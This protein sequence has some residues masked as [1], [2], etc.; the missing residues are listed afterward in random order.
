MAIA[1]AGEQIT[2]ALRGLGVL[3][4]QETATAADAQD[5]LISLNQMLDSWSTERLTVFSMQDQVFTWPASTQIRTLGPSGNFVG[6][7]PVTLDPSTYFKDDVS[8][9]SIILVNQEQY[10]GVMTE[11]VTGE[12]PQVLLVNYTV[13]DVTMT[14]YPTPSKSLDWHFMSIAALSEPVALNT[15]FVLPPGYLR[16]IRYNLMCEIA[17]D[18][19]IEPSPTVQRIAMVSKR[20]LQ[21]INAPRDLMSLPSILTMSTVYNINSGQ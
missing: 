17:P 9:F 8:R 20:N 13:P 3:A 15:Q 19:G 21:W 11:G 10:N 4:A 7:R 1:T 14:V 12:Y 18:Y 16:A 6:I 5:A 2:R